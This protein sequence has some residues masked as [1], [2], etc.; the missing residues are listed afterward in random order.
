MV[1]TYPLTM[2]PKNNTRDG[3]DLIT[4]LL[5]RDTSW[6]PGL[7]PYR[8]VRARIKSR[9]RTWGELLNNYEPYDCKKDR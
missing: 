1:Y 2:G 6:Y 9:V 7:V 3:N 8:P 5:I 4:T